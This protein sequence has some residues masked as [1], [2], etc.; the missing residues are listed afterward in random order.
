MPPAELI[1]LRKQLDELSDAGFIRP[2]TS[3]FRVPVLF[4][5]KK[6][7]A[8]HLCM[9]YRALNKVTIRYRYPILL[10]L[11]LMDRFISCPYFSKLDLQSGYWQVRIAEGDEHKTSCITCYGSFEFLVMLFEL[12]NTPA[13]FCNLINKVLK[14]YL[15]EFVIVYLDDIVVFSASMTE[16]VQHLKLVLEKLREHE[17]KLKPEKYLFRAIEIEFLGHIVGSRCVKMDLAKVH[18]CGMKETLLSVKTQVLFR[19]G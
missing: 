16:H 9:D 17:L 2:S 18:C 7:R 15:D 10:V 8:L 3:P 14:P 11:D 4:Q 19:H 12:T 5:K 6:D 1:E 13:T